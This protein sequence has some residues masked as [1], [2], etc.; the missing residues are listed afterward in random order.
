MYSVELL[1]PACACTQ[2]PASPRLVARDLRHAVLPLHLRPAVRQ[3]PALL[4]V[5]GAVQVQRRHQPACRACSPG[6]TRAGLGTQ[7]K[8]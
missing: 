2:L 4:R 5:Q 6:M 8:T 1:M 7:P 3:A